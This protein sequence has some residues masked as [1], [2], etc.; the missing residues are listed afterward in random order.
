MLYFDNNVKISLFI[1][2]MLN[3]HISSN[4]IFCISIIKLMEKN[5]DFFTDLLFKLGTKSQDMMAI[6]KEIFDFF[7]NIFENVYIYEKEN[8]KNISKKFTYIDKNKNTNKYEI[9]QEYESSLFRFI[10]KLFCNNLERCRKEYSLDLMFLHL[11]N[12][13][14]NSFPEISILLEDKLIP[15]ISFITN[16]SLNNPA[17]KSKEN[18]NF[19]MGN[20]K[21]WKVNENYEKIFCEI[22]LHS[23]NNGMYTKKILSPYFISK[24]P[25]YNINNVE[26][27]NNFDLYPKLP[28]NINMMFDEEFLVKFL[29]S[30]NCTNDLI[31]HLCYEDEDNS[32]NLLT[33]I[34]NYLRQ[35]NNRINTVENIFNKICSLFSI[36]DSLM[37]LRLETLFQLNQNDPNIFPLFDYYDNVKHTEFVLA[38]IFNLAS[39]M[40]QY[41]SIFEYFFNNKHKIQWIYSYF[42]DIKGQGY[43]NDN[44]NKVNSYHPEFMQIIEEGLIN[45]IGFDS[46][47]NQNNYNGISNDNGFLDDD[48]NDGFNLM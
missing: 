13:C 10:K 23:I 46:A 26:N 24:N 33:I 30:Y 32:K 2:N 12:F 47:V 22:I 39:A 45:R 25:N 44:F 1:N 21:G 11:F 31:C 9:L 37:N 38:I 16:N 42:Y 27:N 40:Y 20:S 18:P 4:K 7:K 29:S 19:Y 15:L 34:N 41:N 14:V 28:N 17:F 8:M 43:L 6:N 3:S 48:D 36:N 35:I 5:I